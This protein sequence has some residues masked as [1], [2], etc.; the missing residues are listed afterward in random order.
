MLTRSALIVPGNRFEVRRC[1]QLLTPP[2]W[3]F[4]TGKADISLC[5]LDQESVQIP[6]N[7]ANENTTISKGDE[8][9]VV[10]WGSQQPGGPQSSKMQYGSVYIAGRS[11]CNDMY[12]GT[13]SDGQMC[14]G[15]ADGSVDACSGDSGGPLLLM[16]SGDI[17]EDDVQVFKYSSLHFVGCSNKVLLSTFGP[18]CD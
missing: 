13:I 1:E 6:I 8:L 12:G 3:D 2:A 5:I 15:T 17:P 11:F 4:A 18:T 16:N 9:Q 14:A 7:L 10:G